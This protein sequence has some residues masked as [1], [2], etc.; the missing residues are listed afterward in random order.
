MNHKVLLTGVH[1]NANIFAEEILDLMGLSSKEVLIK[2]EIHLVR[3]HFVADLS[4]K[5]EFIN[6]RDVVEQLSGKI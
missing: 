3:L 5:V 4:I 6:P 2:S 1:K